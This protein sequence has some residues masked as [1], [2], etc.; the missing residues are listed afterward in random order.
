VIAWDYLIT[1]V[2]ANAERAPAEHSVKVLVGIMS[3]EDAPAEARLRA[4]EILLDWGWGR[5]KQLVERQSP[6]N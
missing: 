2:L 4:A 1:L 6:L 3:N 5:P